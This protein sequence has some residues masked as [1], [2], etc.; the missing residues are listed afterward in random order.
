VIF[1]D[2]HTVASV[3]LK[4][5]DPIVSERISQLRTKEEMITQI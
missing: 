5:G 1:V 3:H 2:S 4:K